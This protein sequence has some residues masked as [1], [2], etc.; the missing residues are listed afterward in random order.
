MELF[1]QH[2]YHRTFN[3]EIASKKE[4]SFRLPMQLAKNAVPFAEN[5]NFT[6][7]KP[8]FW[9]NGKRPKFVLIL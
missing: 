9:P 2:S 7:F 8:E 5:E 1:L 3:M 4:I 6:K